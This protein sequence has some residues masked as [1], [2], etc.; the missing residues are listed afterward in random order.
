MSVVLPWSTWAIT[1]TL[2]RRVGSIEEA[3]VAAAGSTAGAA[4]KAREKKREWDKGGE[5]EV[6]DF[7]VEDQRERRMGPTMV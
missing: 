2:R 4:A 5:E 1:A 3:V 6:K 7:L